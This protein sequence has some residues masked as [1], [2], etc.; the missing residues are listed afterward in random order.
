MVEGSTHIWITHQQNNCELHVLVTLH[1]ALRR[2][3]KVARV[4]T[5]DHFLR[6]KMIHVHEHRSKTGMFVACELHSWLFA[7]RCS[8]ALSVFFFGAGH[9]FKYFAGSTLKL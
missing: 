4:I 7:G 8:D 2:K 1:D 5:N 3:M 9:I 6:L